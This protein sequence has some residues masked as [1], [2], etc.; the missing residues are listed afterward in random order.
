MQLHYQLTEPDFREAATHHQRSPT[1]ARLVR[2]ARSPYATI[3]TVPLALGAFYTFRAL[4]PSLESP[5]RAASPLATSADLFLPLVTLA[6]LFF[7]NQI[8][9][10]LFRRAPNWRALSASLLTLASY[11]FAATMLYFV[12]TLNLRRLPSPGPPATPGQALAPHLVWLTLCAAALAIVLASRRR[13]ARL[14]WLGQQNLH[15]PF[16]LD[17]TVDALTLTTPNYA[18]TYA[19]RAIPAVTETPTLFLLHLSDLTFHIVPKRALPTPDAQS[20]FRHMLRNLTTK[21]ATPSF[22]VLP[23]AQT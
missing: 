14:L 2:R 8:I 19:W 11:L 15:L 18:S 22:P 7:L 20:A 1:R 16:T 3:V 4:V 9:P 17:A 6:L 23:A 21:P 12:S 13:A 5:D 10:A